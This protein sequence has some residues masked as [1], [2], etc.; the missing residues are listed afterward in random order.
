M[1]TGELYS[2]VIWANREQLDSIL[3]FG[4]SLTM[5]EG[6]LEPNRYAQGMPAVICAMVR[7]INSRRSPEGVQ[8]ALKEINIQNSYNPQEIFNNTS[9][10]SWSCLSNPCQTLA[11]EA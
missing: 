3:I 1:A 9:L 7:S 4:N 2:N 5:Y 6:L 11:G 8:G 10:H